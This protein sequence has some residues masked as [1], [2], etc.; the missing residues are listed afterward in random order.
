MGYDPGSPDFV[1][2]PRLHA[3]GLAAYGSGGLDASVREALAR[4]AR[5][6]CARRVTPA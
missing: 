5:L 6:A 2:H 1:D 4:R 3:I